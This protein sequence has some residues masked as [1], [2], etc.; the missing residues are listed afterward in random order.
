MNSADTIAAMQMV[1]LVCLK[2]VAIKACFTS[3]TIRRERMLKKKSAVITVCVML[4]AIMLTLSGCG[5]SKLSGTYL[6]PD[7][8]SNYVVFDGSTATFYEDG[9]Q[10]RS[11]SFRESAKTS[12]GQYMLTVT[13]ESNGA[14]SDE[15]FWLDEKKEIV[16]EAIFGDAAGTAGTVGEVAF[17]KK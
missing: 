3:H 12:S 15:R 14:T 7:D 5:G 13:F 8:N 6:S 11:G 17:I 2:C 10:T 16:Y 9:S 1:M 4:M